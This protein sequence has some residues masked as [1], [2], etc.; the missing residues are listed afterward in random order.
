[1]LIFSSRRKFVLQSLSAMAG[2]ATLIRP[3]RAQ[4]P[5]AR[6]A[7]PLGRWLS[8]GRYRLPRGCHAPSSR[9]WPRRRRHNRTANRTGVSKHSGRACSIRD[10]FCPRVQGDRLPH[11][12]G[13][14]DPCGA[15][16]RAVSPAANP[17]VDRRGCSSIGAVFPGR[18]RCHGVDPEAGL[19]W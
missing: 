8:C 18:N 16:A 11:E 7:A 13:R 12:H 3:S 10:G 4:A 9:D 2:A 6:S 1:M 19:T 14:S 15:R 17:I 5:A